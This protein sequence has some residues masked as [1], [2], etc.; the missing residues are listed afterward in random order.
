MP[1]ARVSPAER[2]KPACKPRVNRSRKKEK[3]TGRLKATVDW[4]QR[5]PWLPPLSL[6]LGERV[7]RTKKKK[8]R[9]GGERNRRERSKNLSNQFNERTRAINQLLFFRR[10][11]EG[12]G[13]E[14]GRSVGTR[15][16]KGEG[17]CILRATDVLSHP[18][19]A[20]L[21]FTFPP[22]CSPQ[23]GELISVISPIMRLSSSDSPFTWTID[24]YCYSDSRRSG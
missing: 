6:S 22:R 18:S 20:T 7:A 5:E 1:T 23:R 12:K 11:E 16:D 14:E 10:E 9:R 24:Y 8:K 3:R 17:R 13:T 4:R 21:S 19:L 15:H 2:C